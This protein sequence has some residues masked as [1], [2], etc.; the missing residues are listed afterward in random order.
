MAAA[1]LAA[2]ALTAWLLVL[3]GRRTFGGDIGFAA[4]ALFLLLG[5]PA[6]QRLGGVRVRAQCETFIA[7]AVTAALVLAAHRRPRTGHLF[8][9]GIFLGVAFWLRYNAGVYLIPA[10]AMTGLGLGTWGLQCDV[11]SL[12]PPASSRSCS[13]SRAFASSPWR[14]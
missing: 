8:L 6:I 5:N 12:E 13:C 11:L 14:S 10:L 9:A 7:L 3:L 2:A 4:A 1:D